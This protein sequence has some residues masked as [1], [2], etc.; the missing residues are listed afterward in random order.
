M[1]F[2]I[3]QSQCEKYVFIAIGICFDDSTNE[4]HL[5]DVCWIIKSLEYLTFSC[6]N[7]EFEFKKKETLIPLGSV[8][9]SYY[10]YF[11]SFHQ[12]HYLLVC[13]SV[14]GCGCL[15]WPDQTGSFDSASYLLNISLTNCV[16]YASKCWLYPAQFVKHYTIQSLG[17][18][19]IL[20]VLE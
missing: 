1:A 15:K 9:K 17:S 13:V 14:C 18:M 11:W 6:E 8:F 2:A 4:Q 7:T 19:C 12:I 3:F 16:C 5:S 10:G 20:L